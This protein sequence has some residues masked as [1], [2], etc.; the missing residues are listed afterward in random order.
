MQ[1][2]VSSSQLD[3]L[4][5]FQDDGPVD[6]L[7]DSKS[8]GGWLNDLRYGRQELRMVLFKPTSR[9]G[10]VFE[11]LC[12]VWLDDA[13][14]ELVIVYETAGKSKSGKVRKS[15][16]TAGYVEVVPPVDVEV[17][18][19]VDVEVVSSVDVEVLPSVDVEVVPSVDVEVVPSVDVEIVPSVDVEFVPSVDVEVVVAIDAELVS[20][21]S[22]S[23][24][25]LCVASS[26][27]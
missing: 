21:M 12:N 8:R 25:S 16:G 14:D 23:Y 5:G 4:F 22:A 24:S 1:L 18:S 9:E 19:P 3:G 13:R 15:K 20:L 7:S 26:A 11:R 27:C 17:V 6:C 10:S 2:G